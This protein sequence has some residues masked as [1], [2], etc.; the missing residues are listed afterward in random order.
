MRE[1]RG[2]DRGSARSVRELAGRRTNGTKFFTA[3]FWHSN[4][5]AHVRGGDRWFAGAFVRYP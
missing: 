2:C 5:D 4:I 1:A 3:S